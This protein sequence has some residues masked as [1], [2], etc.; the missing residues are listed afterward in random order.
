M[1]IFSTYVKWLHM[2]QPSFTSWKW[3]MDKN[4]TI[5]GLSMMVWSRKSIFE[6][7][8]NGSHLKWGFALRDFKKNLCGVFNADTYDKWNFKPK[9]PPIHIPFCGRKWMLNH[10]Y[11]CCVKF[12]LTKYRGNLPIQYLNSGELKFK[13]LPFA[14]YQINNKVASSQNKCIEKVLSSAAFLPFLL[15]F[16][17]IKISANGNYILRPRQN[18]EFQY[19]C[20]FRYLC[21]IYLNFWEENVWMTLMTLN[22]DLSGY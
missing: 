12:V 17:A 10:S 18:L 15:F 9:I 1:Y 13:L 3:N 16:S 2:I 8:T 22:S 7:A 6:F 4:F 11:F 21:F 5:F 19:V 14:F 20:I